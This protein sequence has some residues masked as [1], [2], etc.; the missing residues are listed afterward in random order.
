MWGNDGFGESPTLYWSDDC[1]RLVDGLQCYDATMAPGLYWS[2]T[3]DNHTQLTNLPCSSSIQMFFS[4]SPNR[5][6]V[7]L[8]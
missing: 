5:F 3:N 2:R 1:W 8:D 7:T 4:H 6:L